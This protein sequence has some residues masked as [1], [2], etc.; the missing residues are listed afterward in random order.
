MCKTHSREKRGVGGREREG[1][2]ERGEVEKGAII[3][4][5][6]F[7]RCEEG[8]LGH[9]FSPLAIQGRSLSLNIL[10]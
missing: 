9:P 7:V 4:G 6:L 8:G 5:I 1:G 2:R 10:W 3:A